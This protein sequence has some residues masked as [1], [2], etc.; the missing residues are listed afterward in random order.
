[1]TKRKTTPQTQKNSKTAGVAF[2]LL[3]P[4]NE[5]VT[6]IGS[7]NDWKPTPMERGDDGVWRVEIPLEDGEYEYKFQLKSKSYFAE[8]QTVTVADPTSLQLTLNSRENSLLKVKD[9]QPVTLTYEWQHNDVPLP[10]NDQLIIYE[11]HVGD[12]CGDPGNNQPCK[13]EQ[14][15]EKLDY[16]VDLGVNAVELMP[17]NEFPGH[18]SWGY[19]QRSIYAIENT[20]GSPDELCRLV[21]ECHARGIRVIHDAVYNHME[22]DAP[23][24]QIDYTYWFYESNPDGQ[25]LDWG[26]KFNYEFY[27][28]ALKR[29]PAREHVI[30]AMRMWVEQFHIDGIRFDATRALRYYDLLKWFNTEAHSRADFK[31]FYTIAEHI[32]QDSTIAGPEGPMDAAWHDNFLRQMRATVLGVAHEGRE[33]FLTDEVLRLLHGRN[34]GFVSSYNTIHYLATHDE[35]RL[36]YLLGSEAQTFDDAAF[37]RAKLGASLLLTSP[38]IP[39]IWMG[40]EFGQATPRTL[41]PTPLQ[42]NLLENE[43]NQGLF[44]HYR[45]LIHLRKNNP[46]LY[47]ENYEPVANMQ[48]RGIIGYKR[49]NDQGNLVVVV[50]NLVDRYAGQFE[51]PLSGIEDGQWREAVYNYEVGVQNGVLVD[52]LAESEVKI[53]IKC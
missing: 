45:N 32:P 22:A 5:D 9:G 49:W 41:D 19:S 44:H 38:G 52:T 42:W 1:M 14:V 40:E 3:A 26:P 23:L 2:E 29:W 21:D 17:V 4:Y 33:P 39:M 12:F 11:M 35:N 51:I 28:E 15:I 25:E 24:T 16:L 53:Y 13:F 20:Y 6:V 48:G 36:M 34:D 43:R 30:G 31:P 47:S 27:D 18:H 46:A 37:R 10:P 8:G 7:W 50:A